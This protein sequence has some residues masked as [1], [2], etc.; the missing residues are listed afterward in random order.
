[1]KTKLLFFIQKTISF[2]VLTTVNL[3]QKHLGIENC[4]G[5]S[6]T[7]SKLVRASGPAINAVIAFKGNPAIKAKLNDL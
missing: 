2:L 5:M 3:I 1:M 7:D 4:T 6:T